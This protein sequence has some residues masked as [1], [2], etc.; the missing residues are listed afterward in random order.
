MTG[1]L[2]GGGMRWRLCRHLISYLST[3]EVVIARVAKQS[4]VFSQCIFHDGNVA[5][6]SFL[7]CG[8]II[9]DVAICFNFIKFY[10]VLPNMG[11]CYLSNRF[12]FDVN[13][14]LVVSHVQ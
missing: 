10:T 14:L 1:V 5:I 3:N 11:F 6:C 2:N 8:F 4:V 12:S 13:L 7:L 9:Y